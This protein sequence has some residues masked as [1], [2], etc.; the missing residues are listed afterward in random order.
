M[1]VIGDYIAGLA[2]AYRCNDRIG[3]C[4]VRKLECLRFIRLVSKVMTIC[5]FDFW[6]GGKTFLIK[7]LRTRE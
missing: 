6:R 4:I 7:S 1:R 2:E 3:I 5:G